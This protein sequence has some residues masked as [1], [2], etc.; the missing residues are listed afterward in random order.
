M[1][2][3]SSILSS[4]VLWS[5]LGVSVSVIFGV[6]GIY[7][8]V[9]SRY[10]GAITFVNEQTIELFDAIGN[11]LDNLAVTYDGCDVNDN[12]VLLNGAFINSGKMDLTKDMVEKPIT[13]I[14]PD[15]FKW[16]SGRIIESK[17]KAQLELKDDNTISIETGLFRR[18]EC[19]RF[20]ALA[21]LPDNED[22]DSN[23]KRL[24]DSLKFDHRIT[25]TKNIN[26]TE[27]KPKKASNKELKRRGIPFLILF[28]LLAGAMSFLAYTGLPKIMVFPYQV[29]TTVVENV[30]VKITHEELVKVSSISSD[31]E[32]KES[33]SEFI[34]KVTGAPSLNKAEF[35]ISMILMFSIQILVLLFIPG[36]ATY[37][38]IRNR[39]L[40]KIIESK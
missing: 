18:G 13:I 39:R 10:S 3:R 15:G 19:V 9:K 20:H 38:Y 34:N 16:L 30:K 1:S 26:E 25:N 37:E 2:L 12:L 35:E 11:S 31:F 6:V 33:F 4:E 32:R 23:S 29:E 21:Q 7:L 24:N 8:T 5:V 28:I 36:F 14:L 27:V 17:V 22:G 40:L